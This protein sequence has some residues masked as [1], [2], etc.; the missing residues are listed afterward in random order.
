V[1]VQ[2]EDQIALI[3]HVSVV[4]TGYRPKGLND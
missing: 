1:Q 4:F 2:R 3:I